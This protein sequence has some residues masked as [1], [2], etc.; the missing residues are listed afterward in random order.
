MLSGN[1]GSDSP[2]GPARLTV[3]FA[4]TYG[5]GEAAATVMKRLAGIGGSFG[6]H[7]ARKV[8]GDLNCS[9][10][11]GPRGGLVCACGCRN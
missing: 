1:A 8:V 7:R 6:V 10:G 3:M 9:M 5:G 4:E 2:Q 11:C